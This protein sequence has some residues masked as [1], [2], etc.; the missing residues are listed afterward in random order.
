M[1]VDQQKILTTF[2]MKQ[3]L[4]GFVLRKL[5]AEVET[6]DSEKPYKY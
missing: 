6:Q 4:K 2:G 3:N 1:V 5:T